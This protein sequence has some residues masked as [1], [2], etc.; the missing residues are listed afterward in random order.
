MAVATAVGV[1]VVVVL[2]RDMC[3]SHGRRCRNGPVLESM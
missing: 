1:V 2:V 3:M